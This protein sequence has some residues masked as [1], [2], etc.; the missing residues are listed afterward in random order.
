MTDLSNCLTDVAMA[1]TGDDR[2][3]MKVNS[4]FASSKNTFLLRKKNIKKKFF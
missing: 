4:S 2:V 1:D 3:H